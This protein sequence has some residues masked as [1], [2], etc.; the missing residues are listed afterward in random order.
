MNLISIAISMAKIFN[1]NQ[2]QSINLNQVLRI[3]NSLEK[4]LIIEKCGFD[5]GHHLK[6]QISN[7]NQSQFGNLNQIL[8]AK[9]RKNFLKKLIIKKCGLDFSCHPNGQDFYHN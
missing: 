9:G 3:K 4:K 8:K 6:D 7:Y 2:S 5:F 1:Q